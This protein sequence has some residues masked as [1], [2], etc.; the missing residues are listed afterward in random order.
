MNIFP[1]TNI[2]GIIGNAANVL[3]VKNNLSYGHIEIS[4]P[5]LSYVGG[6]SGGLHTDFDLNNIQAN[7]FAGSINASGGR[8]YA[9]EICGGIFVS[10]NYTS[11][12]RYIYK[13]GAE[14]FEY[15]TSVATLEN[16]NNTDFYILVLNLDSSIWNFDYLDYLNNV[17]PYLK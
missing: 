11:F 9:N 10:N 15:A 1:R 16:L 4:S 3:E 6:I 12:D 13:Y 2:G 8:M 14:S 17:L 7:L 5:Y